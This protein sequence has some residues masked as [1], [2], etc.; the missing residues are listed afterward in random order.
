MCTGENTKLKTPYKAASP[1]ISF[2]V[3]S[4]VI[5]ATA[6]LVISRTMPSISE[7]EESQ[8]YLDM[9]TTMQTID[10][11][12]NYV[13]HEYENASVV[14]DIRVPGTLKIYDNLIV[15]EIQKAGVYGKIKKGNILI[16]GNGVTKF[17]LN[18]TNINITTPSTQAFSRGLHRI[19]IVNKG[20]SNNK[21]I[22]CIRATNS[23]YKC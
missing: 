5:I 11:Y 16:V 21:V 4:I 19:Q 7:F 3:L 1:L 2:L 18:Y 22:I 9:L 10:S 23:P 14:I 20:F 13:A 15:G 8:D 6:S 17:Y 12:I